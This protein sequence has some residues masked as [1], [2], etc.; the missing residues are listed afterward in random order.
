MSPTKVI[1]TE[2]DIDKEINE[3]SKL[4]QF[5]PRAAITAREEY[6]D[7]IADAEEPKRD[8]QT[9]LLEFNT[10]YTR[11]KAEYISLRSKLQHLNIE[12]EQLDGLADELQEHDAEALDKYEP[13]PEPVTMNEAYTAAAAVADFIDSADSL[14][15]IDEVDQIHK[16]EL[17]NA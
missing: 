17:N 8:P 6:Q 10:V 15:E 12:M 14:F 7:Y 11:T 16:E 2:E 13:L 1:Q 3:L 4:G 9:I 5:G